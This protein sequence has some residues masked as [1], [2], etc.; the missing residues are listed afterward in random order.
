MIIN[1]FIFLIN[2]LSL[3]FLIYRNKRKTI[4]R[5]I[6]ATP[7]NNQIELRNVLIAGANKCSFKKPPRRWYSIDRTNKIES[8]NIKTSETRSI[9]T[10]PISLSNGTFSAF[11]NAAQRLISPRRGMAR[12]AK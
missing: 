3:S 5:K 4:N 7:E 9:I 2:K 1:F 11:F 12:F 8:N 10:V 6:S